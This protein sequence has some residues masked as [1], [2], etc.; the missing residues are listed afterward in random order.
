MDIEKIIDFYKWKWFYLYGLE[1]VSGD[2]LI[3]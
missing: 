1:D 3:G 2:E